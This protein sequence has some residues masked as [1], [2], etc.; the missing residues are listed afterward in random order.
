LA[1]YL[2]TENR[3]YFEAPLLCVVEAKKDDF[4]QGL[5]QCLLEIAAC[6]W[7]NRQIERL[8]DV[9][10]VVTNGGVWQFYQFLQDGFVYETRPYAISDLKS[11]LGIL[12]H[13]FRRCEQQL[14]TSTPPGNGEKD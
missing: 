1:D 4:E 2:L 12:H 11:I 14:E 8:L 5:A 13:L 6:Q 10:G 7:S 9:L 3:R